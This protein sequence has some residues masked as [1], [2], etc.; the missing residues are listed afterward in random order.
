MPMNTAP[1]LPVDPHPSQVVILLAAYRG[2]DFIQTQLD[3]IAAQTHTNWRLIV[4][5]DSP[6]DLTR[7]VILRFAADRP[8]GQVSVI[9][10]PRQGATQNFLHLLQQAPAGRMLAFADQDDQ[11]LPQ[12]L[13]RA[14]QAL[15]PHTAP[16]HYAARTIIADEHLK[17]ITETRHFP[18]PLTFRNA[19]VQA[20][21]AGNT[22]VFNPAAAA[23][24]QEAA[25]AA[26][27]AQIESHDWWAYQ[28][29]SGAGA[30]MIHDAAPALLYRQHPQSEMGR[31]DTPGAMAK[32]VGML[33]AGDFGGWLAAN[34]QALSANRH[35]LTTENADILDRFGDA[36]QMNGP[37]AAVQLRRIGLYR[38]TSIG[39]GALFAAAAC[40]RL[41]A[42]A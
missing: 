2:Q 40:G 31:N 20:C 39:T 28:L 36:L 3:S 14:V 17:P 32:R 26:R 30:A 22:S 25:A 10:G 5:D 41:K 35:L 9:G 16:A 4:S 42:R 38:Q 27:D 18:R 15:S 6:D 33:F 8:A 7:T 34:H 11:W 13:A 29:T 12:K 21:M 23:L 24:L 1:D 37:R 19:L